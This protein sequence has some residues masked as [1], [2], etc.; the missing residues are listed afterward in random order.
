MANLRWYKIEEEIP[1]E[2][3]IRQVVVAGK[4]LCLL[5]TEGK[6]YL[7][8][9]TCPHA[10]GILSG[11]WCSSGSIICPIHRYAYNL[12][13]GRGAEGQGDYID[14]YP[15]RLEDDGLYAGFHQSL[16]SRFFWK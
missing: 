9:N 5:R 12:E 13:N 2:D 14:V 15:L 11:G 16:F 8:Q 4:K 10:G 7:I 3:F 6:I 1:V